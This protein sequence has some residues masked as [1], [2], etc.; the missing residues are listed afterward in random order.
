MKEKSHSSS[1][2]THTLTHPSQETLL[3]DHKRQKRRR[4]GSLQCGEKGSLNEQMATQGKGYGALLVNF[5]QAKARVGRGLKCSGLANP[6]PMDD[7][8][9]SY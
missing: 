8:D 6:V 7:T 1:P 3:L 4:E 5:P 2:Y 9:C